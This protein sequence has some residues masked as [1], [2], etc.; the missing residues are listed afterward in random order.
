MLLHEDPSSAPLRTGTV[1][2][3]QGNAGRPICHTPMMRVPLVPGPD[4]CSNFHS[5]IQF[6][7]QARATVTP[8]LLGLA[9]CSLWALGLWNEG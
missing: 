7:P 5:G 1:V 2:L 8:E 9:L 3:Y 6:I 4:I